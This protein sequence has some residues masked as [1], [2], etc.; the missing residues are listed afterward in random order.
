M[1]RLRE[2]LARES[3]QALMEV[4]IAAML[5]PI[6]LGAGL[7]TATGFNGTVKRNQDLND[8]QARTREAVDLLARDLRNLASPTPEQPE[9]VDKAEPY[10]LVF[11]SVDPSGAGTEG[12]LANVRRMRY[13]LETGVSGPAKLWSQTQTWTSA[14]PPAM[15]ATTACPDPAWG[16]QR[17]LAQEI[18]NRVNGQDRP[19]FQFNAETNPQVTAIIVQAWAQSAG[20]DEPTE[21]LLRSQVFLRNQNEAPVAAPTGAP[22]GL[23]RVQLNGS[24]SY[25]PEGQDLVYRWYE[26]DTLLA[27]GVVVDLDLTAGLHD[28][29]LKVFDPAGLEGQATTQVLVTDA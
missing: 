15:P 25:D 19:L 9:A 11:Q 8:S 16:N 24:A 28:I 13:C 17:V 21:G 6:V 2:R 27:T 3:G 10:D 20:Q 5:T 4:L 23:L 7:S 29:T 18:T 26:G 22:I 1:R 12:N 14:T